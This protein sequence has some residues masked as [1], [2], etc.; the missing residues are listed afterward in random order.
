MVE[1]LLDKLTYENEKEAKVSFHYI[2]SNKSR[3]RVKSTKRRVDFQRE[4]LG[5]FHQEIRGSS[6]EEKFK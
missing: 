4:M 3:K 1:D 5:L 6:V 2:L